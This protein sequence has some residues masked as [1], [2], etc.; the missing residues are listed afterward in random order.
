MTGGQGLKHCRDAQTHTRHEDLTGIRY[1]RNANRH[2]VRTP[3]AYRRCGGLLPIKRRP[4][5]PTYHYARRGPPYHRTPAPYVRTPKAINTKKKNSYRHPT[6]IRQGTSHQKCSASLSKS[7][8]NAKNDFPCPNVSK[9]GQP[10]DRD[11]RRQIHSHRYTLLFKQ[12]M[13][14][15]TELSSKETQSQG[16]SRSRVIALACANSLSSQLAHSVGSAQEDTG[17][18]AAGSSYDSKPRGSTN[19]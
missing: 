4:D 10:P 18:R 13:E 3:T 9:R 1:L 11:T 16:P 2:M 14:T 5:F 8:A 6:S 7:T 12:A 15:A 19:A 17:E